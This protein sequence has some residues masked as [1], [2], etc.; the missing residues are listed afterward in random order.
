MSQ[1]TLPDL[2]SPS[3]TGGLLYFRLQNVLK[4]NADITS[5]M[6]RGAFNGVSELEPT[7]TPRER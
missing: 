5:R 6:S 7:H 1:S 3:P 4:G 2:I